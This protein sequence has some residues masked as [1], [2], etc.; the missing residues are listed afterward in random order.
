MIYRI[1]CFIRDETI[2]KSQYKEVSV[3]R[4]GKNR[5]LRQEKGCTSV[6]Y[7]TGWM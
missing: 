3:R 2:P 7:T 1:R 6:E 5:R 4:K